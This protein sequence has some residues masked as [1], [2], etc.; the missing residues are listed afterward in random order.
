MRKMVTF[1]DAFDGERP[2]SRARDF[3]PLKTEAQ[4]SRGFV[5]HDA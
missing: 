2:V 4:A 5:K 3:S 1:E